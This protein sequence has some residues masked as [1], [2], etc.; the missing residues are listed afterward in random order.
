MHSKQISIERPSVQSIP[1]N[2][3]VLIIIVSS[4]TRIATASIIII[5]AIIIIHN[6]PT[7]QW[8]AAN[9]LL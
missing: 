6:I 1:K 8:H 9:I 4:L 5:I 3:P 2:R 7:A